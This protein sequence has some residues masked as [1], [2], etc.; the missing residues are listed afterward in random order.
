[1]GPKKRTWSTIIPYES[2]DSSFPISSVCI[3]SEANLKPIQPSSFTVC[4]NHQ[5][6]LGMNQSAIS[7]KVSSQILSRFGL[8]AFFIFLF[9]KYKCVFR[10]LRMNCDFK[11]VY[12]SDCR[13]ENMMKPGDDMQCRE[14]GYRILY[15][16]RIYRS[17]LRFH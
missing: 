2:L 1:L 9:C 14:C 3:S 4:R 16:K 5:C 7:A 15:K 12:A 11:C 6:V 17:K 10:V 8:M 13:M